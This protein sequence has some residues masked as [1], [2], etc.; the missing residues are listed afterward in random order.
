V[1][2]PGKLR[3]RV[4][5]QRASESRNALGETVLTWTDYTERWA[6]VDGVS[7]REALAAGQSQVEMSHRVR[8]RYVNGLTQSMRIMWQGRKLEI[9]SLLEHGHRSEH[10]LLCQE[11][12]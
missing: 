5:I 7:S 4:T 1:I 9:V 8:L 10:E 11:T 2:D 6:S 3:D 12:T